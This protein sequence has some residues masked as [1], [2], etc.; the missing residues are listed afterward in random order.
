MVDFGEVA[1]YENN[2]K[3]GD[4]IEDVIDYAIMY[5]MKKAY[6]VLLEDSL[7]NLLQWSG[8][9]LG[10]YMIK[11][12]KSKEWCTALYYGAKKEFGDSNGPFLKIY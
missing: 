3:V 2:K 10:E 8:Q 7:Q 6:E 12:G 11:K 1:V 4:G 5:E 9:I